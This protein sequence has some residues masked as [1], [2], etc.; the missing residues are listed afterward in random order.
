MIVNLIY[1]RGV[2]QHM[3]AVWEMN[4][5]EVVECAVKIMNKN[6]DYKND[7]YKQTI[8]FEDKNLNERVFSQLKN[9]RPKPDVDY[10][11]DLDY[12]E[13]FWKHH[14]FRENRF[15]WT[16]KEPEEAEESEEYEEDEEHYED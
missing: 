14:G 6:Y 5:N 15:G 1:H 10:S 9:R 11:E 2:H 7:V 16:I 8:V 12:T 4:E 13:D 3:K